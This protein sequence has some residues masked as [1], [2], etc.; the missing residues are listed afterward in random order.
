MA[1]SNADKTALLFSGS[2]QP[3]HNGRLLSVLRLRSA[4][5]HVHLLG[6]DRA[7]LVRPQ[8]RPS[9][10]LESALAVSIGFASVNELG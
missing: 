2:I 6:V 5:S 4:S 3:V 8:P 9:T 10:P 7:Y 1:F